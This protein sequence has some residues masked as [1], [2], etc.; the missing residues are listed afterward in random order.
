M[1]MR[2]S[3]IAALAEVSVR[4]LQYYDSIGLL[5]P[6][7]T[8]SNGFRIYDENSMEQLK[9]I[10]YY[11]KLNLPLKDISEILA[12]DKLIYE[13]LTERRLALSDQKRHIEKLISEIDD[14]LSKPAKIDNWFDK[15]L[16]DYN[17]S[18]L[19]YCRDTFCVWGM[20][21]YENNTP[22]YLNSKFPIAGMTRLFTA[23]CVFIFESMGLLST[24]DHVNKFIKEFVYGDKIKIYHLITMTSGISD[25]LLEEKWKEAVNKEF[26]SYTEKL[27]YVRKIPILHKIQEQ[28]MK[29]KS[30]EEILEIINYEP[31]KFIPGEE[32]D[33]REINYEILGI[34]MEQVSGKT[35]DKIFEEYI[36]KPLEM[37]DTSF[38]GNMDIV[39]YVNDIPLKAL[40]AC[41]AS[42]GIITTASDLSKWCSAL[43][44][45]KL[46]SEKGRN[47]FESDIFGHGEYTEYG[48]MGEIYSELEVDITEKEYFISVRNKAPVPYNE[49][50]VMYY[51]IKSCDD[52]YV[53]FEIWEMQSG[54]EVRVDSIKIFDKNAEELFS[55]ESVGICVKNG[56]EDRHASDFTDD[57]SYYYELNLS[58]VLTNKFD[59]KETYIA[60]V[61]AQCEEYQSAQF[62]VVYLHDGEWQSSYFN[63]FYCY[64]SAYPLFMEAL[65]AILL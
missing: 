12:K 27:S 58:D 21:D 15:V 26:S 17:Y 1:K 33:Y 63:A 45:G 59:S 39:G 31:L 65:N 48:Q 9:K 35:I 32:N 60:E 29:K 3:E 23:F 44:E 46:I 28:F 49:A 64:E 24:D 10:L 37:N 51:P 57:D 11:R 19:A 8:D 55:E 20:A 25:K 30:Y 54:S 62:G 18:G 4:T 40:Y 42:K 38:F 16:K 2:I 22:F 61:R 13:K 36:F 41:D 5:K 6:S 53:K 47:C 52:G 50:R 56:G 7:E 34:I 14:R 43:I